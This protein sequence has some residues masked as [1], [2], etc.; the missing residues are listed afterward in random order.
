MTSS[1]VMFGQFHI[2]VKIILK[3]SRDRAI[4]MCLCVGGGVYISTSVLYI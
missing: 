2:F 4:D 3:A 1:H